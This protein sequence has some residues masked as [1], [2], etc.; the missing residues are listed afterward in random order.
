MLTC[1]TQTKQTFSFFYGKSIL[2]N[3]WI[4]QD[5]RL[6][7]IQI[8]QPEFFCY[9]KLNYF[10]LSCRYGH[11]FALQI[12]Q[13]L[14]ERNLTSE[15][16]SSHVTRLRYHNCTDHP[17]RQLLYKNLLQLPIVGL[18][19]HA[20][21][22]T[23]LI[24]LFR[25]INTHSAHHSF[26]DPSADINDILYHCMLPICRIVFTVKNIIKNVIDRTLLIV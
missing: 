24:R 22:C 10:L 4:F 11:N 8:G 26:A 19:A 16:N 23:A 3:Y 15:F 7:T 25:L 13:A 17:L 18:D 9:T 14:L 21:M 20:R 1:K 12:K 2:I 5:A 6:A